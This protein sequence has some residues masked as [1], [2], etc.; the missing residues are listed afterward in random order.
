M[1]FFCKQKICS[2]RRSVRRLL[3][4][5][6]YVSVCGCYIP[7][8]RVFDRITAFN[9]LR[10]KLSNN[11]SGS[12]KTSNTRLHRWRDFLQNVCSY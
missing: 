10:H 3:E 11:M 7:V 5:I 4:H 9:L 12:L 8:A 2:G 1:Q 6:F